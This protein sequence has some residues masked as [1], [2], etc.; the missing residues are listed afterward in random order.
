MNSR[1]IRK[2][3]AAFFF[4]STLM[5]T[6]VPAAFAGPNDFF[7]SG[8]ILPGAIGGL[9]DDDDNTASKSSTG[10]GMTSSGGASMPRATA[11]S[12]GGYMGGGN[13]F[14]DDEKRMRRKFTARMAHDKELIAKGE[15]M[16]KRAPNQ[17]D[18]AYKKGKV[19]KEIGEK[20]LADC[21]ANNPMPE[22]TAEKPEKKGK[23]DK[24]DKSM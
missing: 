18:K 21:Q 7:G 11:S 5:S 24:N 10:L 3:Y 15:S 9:R 2:V 19:L 8:Q 16:M 13:D 12:P 1:A 6:P 14:T 4:F 22:E 23:N 17:D 20:D